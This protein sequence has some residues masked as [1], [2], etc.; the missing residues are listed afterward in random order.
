MSEREE[1]VPRYRSIS[2]LYYRDGQENEECEQ[3]A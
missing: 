3:G 2:P 1:I